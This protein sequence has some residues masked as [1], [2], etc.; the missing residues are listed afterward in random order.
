MAGMNKEFAVELFDMLTRRH[1]IEGDSIKKYLLR[2]FWDKISNQSFDNMLQTFFD[3]LINQVGNI[4]QVDKDADG[5]ITEEEVREYRHRAAYEV[6]GHCVCMSKGAAETLKFNMALIL[7]SVIAI[8]ISIR[9]G[10]QT[11]A[12][13]SCNFPR[14]LNAS[15][16]K[17]KP[18]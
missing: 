12:H 15:V 1:N 14:L 11:I 4:M 13:L 17:Y 10:M 9:V 3:M 7:L 6:M 5:R 16:D 8:G 18:I 2:E